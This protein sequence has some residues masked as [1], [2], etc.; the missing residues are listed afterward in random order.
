MT[1]NQECNIDSTTNSVVLCP[2]MTRQIS[3]ENT[4]YNFHMVFIEGSIAII[5][6]SGKTV[7][8]FCPL[9]GQKLRDVPDYSKNQWRQF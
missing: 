2:N 8:Y 1:E 9:C 3:P 7:L 5:C 6:D 4:G